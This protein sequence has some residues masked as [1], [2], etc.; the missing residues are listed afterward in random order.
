M[1]LDY[2]RQATEGCAADGCEFCADYL[3][4]LDADT[5]RIRRELGDRLDRCTDTDHGAA[6]GWLTDNHPDLVREALD[7]TGAPS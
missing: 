6:L 4:H 7:E 2:E 1:N 5:A 3:K